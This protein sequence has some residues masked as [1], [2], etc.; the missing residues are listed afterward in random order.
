MANRVIH[1]RAAVRS[2]PIDLS[3][4]T[5]IYDYEISLDSRLPTQAIALKLILSDG[6][7]HTCGN[8]DASTQITKSYGDVGNCHQVPIFFRNEMRRSITRPQL[9][10]LWISTTCLELYSSAQVAEFLAP[11]FNPV[12][13]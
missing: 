13:P 4:S 8:F 1:N 7:E 2:T 3:G 5:Y 10:R 6:T 11:V 9:L 12:T